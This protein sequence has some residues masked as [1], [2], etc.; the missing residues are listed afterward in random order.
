MSLLNT[1][2]IVY[3]RQE[4]E[5]ASYNGVTISRSK[6]SLDVLWLSVLHRDTYSGW[7]GI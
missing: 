6:S 4:S 3:T 1:P 7:E 2:L 5:K